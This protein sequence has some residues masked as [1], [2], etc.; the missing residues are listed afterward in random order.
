MQN[1]KYI[2]ENTEANTKF[3]YTSDSFPMLIHIKAFII[4]PWAMPPEKF[5][6]NQK[7]KKLNAQ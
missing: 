2:K 4:F 6:K 3:M 7:R 1:H 5:Q